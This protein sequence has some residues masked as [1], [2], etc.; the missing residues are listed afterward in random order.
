MSFQITGYIQ[1]AGYSS[2]AVCGGSVSPVVAATQ[3]PG[4]EISV[5]PAPSP[6]PQIISIATQTPGGNVKSPKFESVPTSDTSAAKGIIA[7]P[8]YAS[9]LPLNPRERKMVEFR[10][11]YSPSFVQGCPPCPV[12]FDMV[13]VS[14]TRHL[15]KQST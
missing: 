12:G 5:L 6:Y 3:T 13:S 14:L 2:L 8:Q 15:G 7:L 9:Y 4:G 1:D 11:N 10:Q